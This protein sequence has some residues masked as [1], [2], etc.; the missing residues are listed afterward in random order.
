VGL[1]KGA[2]RLQSGSGTSGSWGRMQIGGMDGLQESD[3]AGSHS[4]VPLQGHGGQ[5]RSLLHPVEQ[6]GRLGATVPVLCSGGANGQ[7][8]ARF[9]LCPHSSSVLYHVFI[10][11]EYPNFWKG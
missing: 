8:L 1:A 3:R 7:N 4:T 2:R 11:L 10:F 6:D 5:V 9:Q